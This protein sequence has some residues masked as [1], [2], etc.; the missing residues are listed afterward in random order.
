MALFSLP[1]TCSLLYQANL[2][3]SPRRLATT[4]MMPAGSVWRIDRR[5][6]TGVTLL[7]S[8]GA[9]LGGDVGLL[10]RPVGEERAPQEI[11]TR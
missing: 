9:A 1:M 4:S 3:S 7:W 10:F 5:L 8:S 2:R 11:S 6:F